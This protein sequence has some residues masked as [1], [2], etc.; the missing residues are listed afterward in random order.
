MLRI[1]TVITGA[2]TILLTTLGILA[3]PVGQLLLGGALTGALLGIA[4]QQT[5]A[6]IIA[7]IVLL[8]TRTI[9]VGDRIRLHN[10][11]LGGTFE[12]TVTELGLIHC[13]LRT[14]DTPLAIPNTQVLTSAIAVLDP[15]AA[16]PT[17]PLTRRPRIPR[18][19]RRRHHPITHTQVL[20][21][22]RVLPAVTTDSTTTLVCNP[23]EKPS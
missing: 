7:G 2:A 21:T 12:G 10:G 11:T 8:T 1:L 5:L 15:E 23:P 13:H 19:R 18:T 20:R 6:N 3:V 14:T 22:T 17:S 9:A 4:G 16:Q